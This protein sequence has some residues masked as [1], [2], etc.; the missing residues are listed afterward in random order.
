MIHHHPKVG[1]HMLRFRHME[2]FNEYSASIEKGGTGSKKKVKG[3]S[4]FVLDIYGHK[5][6]LNRCE[7]NRLHLNYKK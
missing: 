1:S 3:S 5:T 7:D 2:L 4:T 6:K